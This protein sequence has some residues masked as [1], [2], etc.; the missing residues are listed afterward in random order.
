MDICPGI[1]LLDYMA[2]LFFSFLRNHLVFSTVA[3]PT[4]IPTNSVEGFPPTFIVCR[5]FNDGHS[6][7]C[8]VLPHVV[9]ICISLIISDVEH[10]FMCLLAIY[11]SSLEKCLFR[12]SVHFCI[13]CFLCC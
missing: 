7:L 8:E 4:Y 3:A 1:G 9:L 10:L 11:I 13:G 12:S 2:V 6:D 5:L